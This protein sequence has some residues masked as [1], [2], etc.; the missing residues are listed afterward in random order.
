MKR[1]RYVLVRT[2]AMGVSVG[3]L[4]EAESTETKKVLKNAR[5]IWYWDGAATVYQLATEGTVAPQ[6]CKFSMEAPR[7][8]LTSPSGF[9]M[10]DV[11]DRARES[12]SGVKPWKK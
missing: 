4:D 3:E 10:L 8:E 9:E 12:I 11:T 6:N 2:Y 1:P 7:V 5:K